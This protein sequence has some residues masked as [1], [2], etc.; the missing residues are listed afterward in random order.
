[1]TD[2]QKLVRALRQTWLPTRLV[3]V[4]S[5]PGL[6]L[7]TIRGN[8]LCFA[9]HREYQFGD[10][11]RHL[12]WNVT[13]RLGRPFVKVFEAERAST[14]MIVVDLTS[15]M[16]SRTGLRSKRRATHEVVRLLASF[17]RK[18]GDRVGAVVFGDGYLTRVW[19]SRQPSVGA[20]ILRALSESPGGAEPATLAFACEVAGHMAK[21][22]G[23]VAIV[24]DFLDQSLAAA[25][26]EL[27]PRHDVVGIAVVDPHEVDLPSAGMLRMRDG[28]TGQS[29]I[30]D[31]GNPR[32]RSAYAAAWRRLEEERRRE[33]IRVGVPC[34]EV[35]VASVKSRP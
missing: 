3:A 5:E 11:V 17:G 14:V 15:S 22:P 8:G 2:L 6:H 13:A 10:D 18:I 30:V 32:V 12:D 20:R 29:R 35:A 4:G 9:E 27:A 21:R 34:V 28:E 31:A 25:L 7:S 19:P 24:S 26:D 1:V 23:L 16:S 33:F